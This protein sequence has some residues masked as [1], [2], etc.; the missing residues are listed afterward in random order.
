M[1]S[2][3]RRP[4]PTTRRHALPQDAED[5]DESNLSDSHIDGLRL[6][7]DGL[8]GEYTNRSAALA[9]V[10]GEVAALFK[11]MKMEPSTALEKEIIAGGKALGLGMDAIEQV[12]E[13]A[14]ALLAEKEERVDTI[15]CIGGEIDLLWEVLHVTSEEKAAFFQ[16]TRADLSLGAVAK[17][18]AE[19]S[20]LTAMKTARLGELVRAAQGRLSGLCDALQYGSGARSAHADLLRDCCCSELELGTE[21]GAEGAQGAE[22]AEGGGGDGADA[23]ADAS[24]TGGGSQQASDDLLARLQAEAARLETVL[25]AFR[26]LLAMA[27]KREALLA[28]RDDF[29]LQQK[30]DKNNSR[31][32]VRNGGQTPRGSVVKRDVGRLLREEK[33]QARICKELP[34]LTVLLRGKV[35]KWEKTHGTFSFRGAPY[36][37]ALEA[38]E[39]AYTEAKEQEK[40]EKAMEKKMKLLESKTYDSPRHSTSSSAAAAGG[41][42]TQTQTPGKTPGGRT[43]GKS[44]ATAAAVNRAA[45][46]FKLGAARTPSKLAGTPGK[47][48]GAGAGM[49]G[50]TRTPVGGAL[51]RKAKSASLAGAA[52]TSTTPGNGK[53]VR[54]PSKSLQP[55]PGKSQTQ[56]PGSQRPRLAMSSMENSSEQRG[57]V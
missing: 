12:S 56:T 25:A 20:R 57:V 31:L 21:P 27:E 5:F 6:K 38:Q 36:L 37:P 1:A 33:L 17:C 4:R 55:R 40:Q 19:L 52:A 15:E 29:E 11:E 8:R 3:A 49:G 46:A 54:T 28:E 32:L 16:S 45:G 22:G 24:D 48:A 51:S 9:A 42:Q 39:A 34:K 13:R 14:A 7:L 35:T 2:R 50:A 47:L 23:E 10:A 18:E 26:P 41:G 53:A 43:P 44:L 30:T